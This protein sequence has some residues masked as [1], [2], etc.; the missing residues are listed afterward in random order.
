METR[1]KISLAVLGALCCLQFG[2]VA[3][4]EEDKPT[5]SLAVSA[6]S[7]YVWRGFELSKDSVVFQPSMTVG[8]KG[9]SANVWGN[10]DTD[11]YLAEVEGT[12]TNNWTE[13]DLTLA[14][15][16]TVGP[17]GLTVGYIYYGVYGLDTQEVFGR[18]SW[19]TLLTPTL[20]VYR[21]YDHFTGWYVTLGVSHEVPIT[22]KIKL[23]LGAQVGYL[24]AEDSSTYPEFDG[25]GNGTNKAYSGFHDGLLTAS[26]AIPI[27]EYISITPTLNYSFPLTGEASDLIEST[28]QDYLKNTSGGD[29]NF[30]YGGVT[31]TMAF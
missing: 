6:L 17:V 15:D 14:Y 1:K 20:T 21:D 18:A 26:V 27:T 22:E 24:D 10:V 28:S 12:N 5:A 23:S 19:E 4:A 7:K 13:T 29:T 16:W 3:M 2:G 31:V 25:V 8:Y 30:V 9:F 11:I